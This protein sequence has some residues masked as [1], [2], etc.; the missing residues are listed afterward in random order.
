[1]KLK[2][3]IAVGAAAFAL[4][5]GSSIVA[6]PIDISAHDIGGQ[7]SGEKGLLCKL[8]GLPDMSIRIV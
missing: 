8:E 5:H 7:V 4:L 1:M 6:A 2:Q 3:L